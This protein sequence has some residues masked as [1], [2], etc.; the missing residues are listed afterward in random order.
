MTSESSKKVVLAYQDSA[1]DGK[2]F[3]GVVVATPDSNDIG[4]WSDC[5]QKS[6]F[7]VFSGEIAM[8]Q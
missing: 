8:K 4:E 6:A 5:W 1:I 2:S 3:T 7:E